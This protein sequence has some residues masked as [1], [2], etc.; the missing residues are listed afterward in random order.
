M[1]PYLLDL[2]LLLFVVIDLSYIYAGDV[3]FPSE[4]DRLKD[5]GK[6]H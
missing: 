5:G 1:E 2:L 4:V 6:I 3:A